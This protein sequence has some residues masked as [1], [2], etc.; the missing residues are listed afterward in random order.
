MKNLFLA[1]MTMLAVSLVAC[2]GKNENKS[3]A[4]ADGKSKTLIAYFSASG[5]TKGV[6]E[7]MQKLS[8]A[9]IHE[10]VPAEIYTDADLDWR[11]KQSRSSIEMND[12]KARTALKEPKTD[13]AAF[14]TIYIGYPIWWDLA[15]RVIN[16]WIESNDLKGKVIVPFAT[17]GGSTITNSVKDLRR[18]YPDLDIKDGKLLN[19]PSEAELKTFL[20]K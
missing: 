8:G 1:F 19:S 14:D 2:A 15:P 10:I 7:Q 6:A 9:E 11:N 4:S 20:E 3:E 5:V 16:T 12:D 17:S 13:V 18:L